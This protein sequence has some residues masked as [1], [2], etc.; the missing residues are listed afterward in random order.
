M[1]DASRADGGST[2]SFKK[3]AVIGICAAITLAVAPRAIAADAVVRVNTDIDTVYSPIRNDV[4]TRIPVTPVTVTELDTL[5]LQ[6][7][8]GITSGIISGRITEDEALRLYDMVDSVA[9]QEAEFKLAG[10]TEGHINNLMRKWNMISQETNV[11]ATNGG[12]NTF[13]PNIEQRRESL[14]RRISYHLAAANITPGEAE[15]L[16]TSLDHIT[17]NYAA[18]RATGSTL[19]ADELEAV[20][21]DM[22]SLNG[23]IAE[24]TGGYI[25][26]VVPET[27]E[28]RSAYLNLIRSGLAQHLLT[29]EESAKLIEGYNQLVYTEAAVVA[30]EGPRSAGI[31][32][33]A[34]KIENMQFLLERQLRDRAAV[35][36]TAVA[37]SSNKL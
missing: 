26:R 20:H 2:M 27:V 24:K 18:A 15:Q 14:L 33:L 12:V 35:H 5:K 36:N 13:M 21:K 34:H 29:P 28:E 10:L 37:G 17:D 22:M 1:I 4:E 23:K 30:D 7:T 3:A 11:L 32:N 8:N 6:V 19:S 16:L 25:V 9:Q 31:Q